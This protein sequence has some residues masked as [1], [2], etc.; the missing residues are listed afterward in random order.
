MVRGVTGIQYSVKSV[1]PL[2]A[3]KEEPV[4][5]DREFQAGSRFPRQ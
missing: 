2:R 1:I 4:F 3:R 5:A